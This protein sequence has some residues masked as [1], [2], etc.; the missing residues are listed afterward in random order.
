VGLE[1]GGAW[2]TAWT[3]TNGIQ[4]SYHPRSGSD[5]TGSV[6]SAGATYPDVVMGAGG[7]ALGVYANNPANSND[8]ANDPGSPAAF[9]I[10]PGGLTV[11]Q[12]SFTG[13]YTES[14]PPRIAADR[15]GHAMIVYFYSHDE[16]TSGLL[17]L[18]RSPG[19]T[20]GPAARLASGTTVYP[21]LA[22]DT[23]GDDALLWL[24]LEGA[25]LT[26][27]PMLEI[28]DATSP[29]AAA[30]A[31]SLIRGSQLGTT[32]FPARFSWS[33]SDHLTSAS[34]IRSSLQ[35]RALSGSGWSAWQTL[36]GPTTA[37]SATPS[38]PPGSTFHQFRV[39]VVDQAGNVGASSPGPAFR[40][41]AD[42]ES[43]PKIIYSGTW[44]QTKEAGASGGSVSYSNQAGARATRAFK[45]RN[46][47][48][49]APLRSGEGTAQVC[50]DPGTTHQ[51]CQRIDLSP[52]SGLGERKVVFARNAL[53]P[54]MQHHLQVT[55]VSGRVEL[56]A[57]LVLG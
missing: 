7:E 55:V 25:K 21:V 50:L 27:T 34:Q 22:A 51:S 29:T 40:T 26:T 18:P 38:L 30:P 46:A 1:P 10:T 23:R 57:F 41:L 3:D 6:G 28:Y 14:S 31:Q 53:P 19:G 13:F 56:D 16:A 42:Q 8:P 20:F 37:K 54:T 11:N 33:A 32:T 15:A 44:H 47:A 52:S 12:Q 17:A 45:G 36:A 43:S 48:V 5:V 24:S 9:Q 35:Q 39:Q 4:F 2:I 49:V